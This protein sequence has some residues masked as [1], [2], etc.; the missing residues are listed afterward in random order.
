MTVVRFNHRPFIDYSCAVW[1]THCYL[2][3]KESW[4][5]KRF[6]SELWHRSRATSDYYYC[7]GRGVWACKVGVRER[8]RE[9]KRAKR[10]ALDAL[11]WCG[12]RC[13]KFETKWL[14]LIILPNV[15]DSSKGETSSHFR[16]RI[17]RDTRDAAATSQASFHFLRRAHPR[18]F[19]YR[20]RT[21]MYSVSY[22]PIFHTFEIRDIEREKAR[23]ANA[24]T[25]ARVEFQFREALRRHREIFVIRELRI[26]NISNIVYYMCFFF[27][28]S[29]REF[30][31][32]ILFE[33]YINLINYLFL[34]FKY[35]IIEYRYLKIKSLNYPV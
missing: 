30:C 23:V 6:F 21:R 20:R 14:Y 18:R 10:L 17:W 22:W 33:R 28:S 13:C 29:I 2:C 8:D 35:L 12:H 26:W 15:F 31:R 3:A 24:Q 34:H 32:H 27:I 16:I 19:I 7:V 11:I 5:K 1:D 25:S 9:R 4:K